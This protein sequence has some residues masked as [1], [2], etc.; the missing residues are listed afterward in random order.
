MKKKRK[1]I[2]LIVFSVVFLL[3]LSA[4]FSLFAYQKVYAGKI[5]HNV[6]LDGVNLSGKNTKQAEFILQNHFEPMLAQKITL[7]ANGKTFNTKFAD[8]GFTLDYSAMASNCYKI[9]RAGSFLANLKSSVKTVFAK[10]KIDPTPTI[11]ND[12]YAGFLT[13]M[14]AQL[15]AAPSDSSLGIQDGNV[16][17]TE[18]HIGQTIKTDDLNKRIISLA[19]ASSAKIDLLTITSAAKITNAD[20]AAAKTQAE[21]Y[22]SAQIQFVSPGKAYSP[23][24]AQIGAWIEFKNTNNQYTATV[25][26]AALKSYLD[27]I[28]KSFVVVS[29]N[30]KVDSDTGAVIDP[31]RDGVA[32]DEDKAIADFT[33]QLSKASISV[34][35]VTKTTPAKVVKVAQSQGLELGRFDGKYIDVNL[36]TQ[37]LCKIEGQN[38][39]ACYTVSTGK[40]STPTPTGSYAIIY[41]NPRAWSTSAALWMPWFEEFKD[42]GY[43]LHELPEWPNG[44]KEGEA[45]LGT[46]VSH[47]CIR[48]GVG[49]AEAIFNWT[50]V[51]TPVYIH[52]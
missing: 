46:P 2:A 16:I 15:N 47:G 17:V 20:L 23:T 12:K 11:N 8:T 28:A 41:K 7:S 42:G 39:I 50:E 52:K 35:L 4:F 31:G 24:K 5:Y 40:A 29:V 19:S 3:I 37:T 38:L 22:L 18:G 10:T 49:P 36:T 45:H 43:G 51:G 32:L 9:G 26:N 13:Q 30:Q 14:T 21:S 33:S 44:T 6:Y 34:D 27:T 1:K 25:N 48:L